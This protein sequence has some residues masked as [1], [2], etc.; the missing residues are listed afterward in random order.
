MPFLGVDRYRDPGQIVAMLRR[1]GNLQLVDVR[2][3]EFS[4]RA[5]QTIRDTVPLA[6]AC[7][8]HV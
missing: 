8:V 6:T 4:A 7:V 2:S 5:R 1:L 3:N